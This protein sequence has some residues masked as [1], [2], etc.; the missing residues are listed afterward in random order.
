MRQLRCGPIQYGEWLVPD[1]GVPDVL[2][3][4]LLGGHGRGGVDGVLPLPI[5]LVLHGRGRRVHAVPCGHILANGGARV[6]RLRGRALLNHARRLVVVDVLLLPC[7]LLLCHYGYIRVDVLRQLC[8]GH[9]FRRW[10]RGVHELRG[11]PVR[12]HNW[13]FRVHRL[14]C[15]YLPR[16]YG[17]G[18]V[19]QLRGLR[20]RP[21]L[22]GGRSQ[23]VR[24]MCS[25]HRRSHHWRGELFELPGRRLL[26]LG[27]EPLLPLCRGGVRIKHGGRELHLL[28]RIILPCIDRRHEFFVVHS[29]HWRFKIR[30]RL[31]WLLYLFR[32]TVP[33]QRSVRHLCGRQ[34]LGRRGRCLHA[35]RR[36]KLP[37]QLGLVGLHFLHFGPVPF[38][39]GRRTF[40]P[41]CHLRRRQLRCLGLIKLHA[42]RGGHGRR[43]RR[44]GELRN[45]LRGCLLD[46]QRFDG[47]HV[48]RRRAVP[49]R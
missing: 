39:C 25:G 48:L 3:R 19:D 30:G 6:H 18:C 26:Q 46:G 43:K 17:R 28:P 15:G 31:S 20:G 11:G 34:V 32:G 44:R 5:R 7:R 36:G 41:V 29:L 45:V 16:D 12:Q 22:D 10:R 21:V 33:A 14:L 35:L 24:A 49:E 40:E 42:L 1:L 27:G 23:R 8:G 13:S 47:V 9:I 38:D 2:Q 37:V 4:E